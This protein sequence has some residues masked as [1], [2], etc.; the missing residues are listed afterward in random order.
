[1]HY[2]KLLENQ[3]FIWVQPV[4]KF[5]RLNEYNSTNM[6]DI[7]K[8]PFGLCLEE[9]FI[10]QCEY[11]EKYWKKWWNFILWQ[12]VILHRNNVPPQHVKKLQSKFG[13]TRLLPFDPRL[14]DY[15][16]TCSTWSQKLPSFTFWS[17]FLTMHCLTKILEG[18]FDKASI[19]AKSVLASEKKTPTLTERK[20]HKYTSWRLH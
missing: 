17:I 9:I 6:A 14:L 3:L 7:L 15:N 5:H 4:K 18:I 8:I 2:K 19:D 16:D 11:T 20:L 1:M 10:L 13:H 12:T